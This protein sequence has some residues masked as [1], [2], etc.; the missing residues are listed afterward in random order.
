MKNLPAASCRARAQLPRFIYPTT[1]DGERLSSR[2]SSGTARTSAFC[3]SDPTVHF[4]SFA[5]FATGV[6][7]RAT[8]HNYRRRMPSKAGPATRLRYMTQR[9]CPMRRSERTRDGH[10]AATGSDHQLRDVVN[11]TVDNNG[12]LAVFAIVL[13]NRCHLR[14]FRFSLFDRGRIPAPIW[15][16]VSA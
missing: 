13:N 2:S 12:P 8:L 1:G 7:P 5:I 3:R 10:R 15:T 6:P 16:I 9:L 11:L 14:R 4:V